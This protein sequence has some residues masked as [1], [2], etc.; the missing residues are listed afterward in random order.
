MGRPG[1]PRVQG[2]QSQWTGTSLGKPQ[3]EHP[4]LCGSFYR[5]NVKH[6]CEETKQQKHGA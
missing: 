6:T 5:D 4:G 2:G 3:G 1:Q